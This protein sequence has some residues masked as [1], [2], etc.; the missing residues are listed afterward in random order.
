MSIFSDELRSHLEVAN[1]V[2]SIEEQVMKVANIVID[3]LKNGNKIIICGNGG[4]AA[5]A[6]PGSR[7]R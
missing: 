1:S 7:T 2:L 3:T 6:R 4:S 5:D